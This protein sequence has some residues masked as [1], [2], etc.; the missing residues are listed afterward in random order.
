[1][2][3]CSERG[4]TTSAMMAAKGLRGG[5]CIYSGQQAAHSVYEWV[6]VEDMVRMTYVTISITKNVADMKKDK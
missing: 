6:C 2:S 3:P 1:M 4:G 5:P